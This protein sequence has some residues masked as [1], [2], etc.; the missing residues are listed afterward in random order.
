MRLVSPR[1]PRASVATLPAWSDGG[2]AAVSLVHALAQ[3]PEPP[4]AL[5]GVVIFAANVDLIAADVRELGLRIGLTAGDFDGSAATMNAPAEALRRQGVEARFVSLGRDGGMWAYPLHRTRP[6]NLNRD[7]S[8]AESSSPPLPLAKGYAMRTS[9]LLTR[10]SALL[11]LPFVACATIA[12][13]SSSSSDG[14]ATDAGGTTDSSQGDTGTT[15]GSSTPDGAHD[16]ATTD[17]ATTDSAADAPADAPTSDGGG[18]DAADAADAAPSTVVPCTSGT[19]PDVSVSVGVGLAFV[20]ADVTIQ[21]G[22]TVQWTWSTSDHTVTSVTSG[23]CTADGTFCS[24]TNSD[25]STANTSATGATY[26][27]K[28]TQPGTYPYACLIHCTEGMTGTVTVQ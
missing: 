28:F 6:P 11:V 13:C 24:P 21:A 15:D 12:A 27:E 8:I 26:C 23:T 7:T 9:R 16:S 18:D 19:I 2:Y 1:R 3:A 10:S 14:T 17:S 4:F 22:Q 20:P 5:A 25:C